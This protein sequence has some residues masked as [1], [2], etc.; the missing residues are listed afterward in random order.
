MRKNGDNPFIDP[1]VADQPTD[2]KISKK[3]YDKIKNGILYN[4]LK[5]KGY[6]INTPLILVI[7][8]LVPLSLIIYIAV[9]QGVAE[10][11]ALNCPKDSFNNCLNPFYSCDPMTT[12][13]CPSEKLLKIVCTENAGLC[14]MPLIKAGE[15]Y[16]HKKTFLEENFFYIVLFCVGSAYW[17]NHVLHNSVKQRVER[18]NKYRAGAK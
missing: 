7:G 8:F 9:T 12:S 2:F 10:R 3:E 16:G 11:W 1:E 17:M 15:S 5:A 18:I 4:R 13:W 14:S 6:H